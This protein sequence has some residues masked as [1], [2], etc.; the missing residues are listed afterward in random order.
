M[1]DRKRRELVMLL[2]GAVVWP[3]AARAQKAGMPVIGFLHSGSAAVRT[4]LLVQFHQG[5]S[6]MGM[7]KDATWQLNTA[8]QMI[9]SIDF[10]Y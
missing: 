5:L 9:T 8:G 7:S 10:R 3:F 6:E 2:G 1:F 4:D